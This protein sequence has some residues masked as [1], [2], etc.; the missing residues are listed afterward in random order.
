MT[1]SNNSDLT[2]TI[3]IDLT[4]A[5]TVFFQIVYSVGLS[6]NALL[7]LNYYLYYPIKNTILN[8]G[9]HQRQNACLDGSLL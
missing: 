9:T 1:A 6:Q 5:T 2:A 8:Y 4:I 7:W 3:F